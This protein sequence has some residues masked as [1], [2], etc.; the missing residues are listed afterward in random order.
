MAEQAARLEIHYEVLALH[1][2]RWL[3]DTILR[4]REAALE[5]AQ[6]LLGRG[7]IGGVEVRKELYDPVTGLAAGRTVFRR[8]KPKR[9][10]PPPPAGLATP[11]RGRAGSAGAG[12]G[13]A[14]ARPAASDAPDMARV[15]GAGRPPRAR[16]RP[17][18]GA[19]RGPRGPRLRCRIGRTRREATRIG[20][21]DGTRGGLRALVRMLQNVANTLSVHG[22][23]FPRRP[24]GP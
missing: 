23:R 19:V 6:H 24:P 10:A 21:R 7:E 1:G 17:A 11:A 2:E 18:P 4:E 20:S 22:W 14:A 15:V 13:V 16:G 9:V 3:I 12:A 5:E 8:L